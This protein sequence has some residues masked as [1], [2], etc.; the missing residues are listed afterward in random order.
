MKYELCIFGMVGCAATLTHYGVAL[1]CA[2]LLGIGYQVSN[3]MGFWLAFAVSY[4]GQSI[5]TF[6]SRPNLGSFT[7]YILL[8]IF[9]YFMSAGILF[10]LE[11]VLGIDYRIVLVVIVC[12]IPIIS[13]IVSKFFIFRVAPN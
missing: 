11:S 1:I 7:K 12:L 2:E 4:L 9:N 8:A 10:F 5:L 6:K 13:Y 3:L